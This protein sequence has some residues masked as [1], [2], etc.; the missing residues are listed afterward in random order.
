[1]R[2]VVGTRQRIS[3]FS[4]HAP[5]RRTSAS[6]IICHQKK[7]QETS[8]RAV[9]VARF[10]TRVVFSQSNLMMAFLWVLLN[11]RGQLINKRGVRC[12]ATVKRNCKINEQKSLTLKNQS[13]A[14]KAV[15]PCIDKAASCVAFSRALNSY[16]S[17]F[18]T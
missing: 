6:I 16:R 14:I 10:T 17:T 3:P 2:P 8:S 1:M 5:P 11:L 7:T 12:F 15:V 13:N 4:P 9:F 18:T